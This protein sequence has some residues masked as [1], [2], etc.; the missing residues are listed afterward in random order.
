[1]RTSVQRVYLQVIPGSTG[2]E[3]EDGEEE[4]REQKGCFIGE[5]PSM[6]NWNSLLR[7]SMKQTEYASE[8][9]LPTGEKTDPLWLPEGLACLHTQRN[10]QLES[11]S[12]GS[13]L[14]QDIRS[15]AY[16]SNPGRAPTPAT[17]CKHFLGKLQKEALCQSDGLHAPERRRALWAGDKGCNLGD[18]R[19]VPFGMMVS[20]AQDDDWTAISRELRRSV[21]FRT[22]VPR[23]WNWYTSQCFIKR[24]WEN[25]GRHWR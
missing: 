2:R 8:S 21:N 1:M 12:A 3:M 19:R 5:V 4:E 14:Q 15:S 7:N 22:D 10:R 16:Q 20:G 13:H 24:D 23:T 11:Q 9:L 25:W 18:R 17:G 6:H